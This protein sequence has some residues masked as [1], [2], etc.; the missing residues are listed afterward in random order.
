M[1][2]AI[3]LASAAQALNVVK[4][5]REIDSAMNVA[6]L[7]AKMA[8]LYGNLADVRMALTDA[9]EELRAKDAELAA[10][11]KR[12][13]EQKP[14]AEVHGFMHELVDGKPK[15]LPFCPRCLL[16]GIQ[17]RPVK[18]LHAYQCPNCKSHYS[19]LNHL[20]G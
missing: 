7:K 11:K 17:I 10:L 9:Q 4:Q 2:F 5:L 3:A 19:R 1:D 15:G 6:E 14:M 20:N 8:E 16:D 18:V 12:Q 13:I